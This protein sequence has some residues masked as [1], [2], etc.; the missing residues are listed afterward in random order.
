[1]RATSTLAALTVIATTSALFAGCG[2]GG[3]GGGG[4]STVAGATSATPTATTSATAAGSSSSGVAAIPSQPVGPLHRK[5]LD[6]EAV[7]QAQHVP[8]GL[9]QDVKLDASGQVVARSG[10]SR[11]LWTGLYAATEAARFRATGDPAA[12]AAMEKA[13]WTL[14]DLAQVTGVRGA[15]AR[16]FDE[17]RFQQGPPGAGRYAQFNYDPGK[18]SRDQYTGWFYGVGMAWESI[19][20]PALRTALQDDARAV[21]DGLMAGGLILKATWN[22]VPDTVLMDL[23]PTGLSLDNVTPQTWATVDDFPLNLLVQHIPYDPNLVTALQQAGPHF[24]P[25]RAGEAVRAMLMFTVTEHIT[26]DPR[27]RSAKLDLAYGPKD[28]QGAIRDYLCIGDDLFLGRNQAVVKDAL[29]RVFRYIGVA[30]QLW[31]QTRGAWGIVAP[32]APAIA[33]GLGNFLGNLAVDIVDALHDPNNQTKIQRVVLGLRLLSVV[34]NVAGMG[35]TGQSIDRFINQYLPNLNHAGLVELAK[36]IRSY[37]MTNLTLMPL[38]CLSH[39]ESDPR[40]KAL[41]QD[42][43]ERHWVDVSTERNCMIN[44]MHA[45]Y[46]HR[47][48]TNDVPD[49]IDEL[50]RYPT[51]LRLRQIDHRGQPGVRPSV[52]PDRFG[53][54]TMAGSPDVFRIDER[55]PDIFPWRGNPRKLVEGSND[56]ST[57]VAPLGYLAPYWMARDRGLIGPAD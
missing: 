57:H 33:Q 42:G 51:D 4:A 20:D 32:L 52:W 41:Y 48:T 47:T 39:L 9:V 27:Y 56:P 15:F 40:L 12:R 34:F 54:A 18:P 23:N 55:A 22:G 25:V 13:L 43:F 28:L 6:F 31:L 29:V 53:Q 19:Q 46:G 11:C 8:Y 38:A 1:M 49:L 36:V 10:P 3:S 26:G 5:A 7:M 30:V 14:H 21:T 44:A 17:P 2:G 37:L 24:P 35:N 50:G 45:G 16:A